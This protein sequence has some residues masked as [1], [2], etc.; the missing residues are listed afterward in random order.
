[1]AETDTVDISKI[2]FTSTV[3]PT[4]EDKALWASLSDV[5][6]EAL[7]IAD[8]RKAYESGVAENASMEKLLTE[9][10]AE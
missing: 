5:E 1:M 7:L 8:E 6:R 9:T 3:C 10:R 2:S 4:E